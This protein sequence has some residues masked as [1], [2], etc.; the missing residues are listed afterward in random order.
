MASSHSR[1]KRIKA[2]K[3]LKNLKNH[4]TLSLALQLPNLLALQIDQFESHT[5]W[6]I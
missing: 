3:M 1:K 6:L 4:S 2:K 5:S